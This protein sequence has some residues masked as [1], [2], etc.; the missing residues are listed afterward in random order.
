MFDLAFPLALPFWAVMI[1]LPRWSWA[2]SLVGSPWIVAAPLVAYGIALAPQLGPFVA[3][4]AQPSFAGVRALFASDLG[5]AA[6]WAH[7]IAFDLFVGRW[8]YLDACQ[9]GI[10]PLGMARS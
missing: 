5:T 9:R 8:M 3:A 4:V 1:L 6:I 2:R 7:L 10:H